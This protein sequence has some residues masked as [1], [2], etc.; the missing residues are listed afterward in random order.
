MDKYLI[1]YVYI[2]TGK[3]K[4]I[5]KRTQKIVEANILTLFCGVS[6]F[7]LHNLS[8]TASNLTASDTYTFT[9]ASPFINPI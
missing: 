2:P 7:C 5:L 4:T 9:P 6:P 8:Q 3:Y 1:E